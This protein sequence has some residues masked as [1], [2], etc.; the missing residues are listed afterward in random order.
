MPAVNGVGVSS[1]LRADEGIA[2][3]QW[4]SPG[5]YA[6]DDTIATDCTASVQSGLQPLW[7]PTVGLTHSC[8][9]RA[10]GCDSPEQRRWRTSP[11][12][13]VV[14]CDPDR[15]RR[16]VTICVPHAAVVYSRPEET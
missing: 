1:R 10:S 13:S 4:P 11:H 3:R 2:T 12:A 6:L 15:Y 16:H 9:E 7:L 8:Q 14:E 5:D